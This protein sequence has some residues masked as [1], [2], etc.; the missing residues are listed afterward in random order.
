MDSA[1]CLAALQVVLLLGG[2]VGGNV[3]AERRALTPCQ[4]CARA[5]TPEAAWTP[6][7][8]LRN[9]APLGYPRT[10]STVAPPGCAAPAVAV[11]STSFG[12]TSGPPGLRVAMTADGGCWFVGGDARELLGEDA[13]AMA[14]ELAFEGWSRAQRAAGG[15]PDPSC[16]DPER[17]AEVV[18]FLLDERGMRLLRTGDE[19]FLERLGR[20]GRFT[21]GERTLARAEAGEPT[22]VP[23]A[24]AQ[25]VEFATW[26]EAGGDIRRHRVLAWPDGTLRH[27]EE[28]IAEEIGLWTLFI[29]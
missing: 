21:R 25:L 18:L 12:W 9:I 1:S 24:D 8:G 26:S 17:V 4:E 6:P 11:R 10:C 5:V 2:S 23:M 14:K 22:A 20:G 16:E 15:L 29:R 19:P 13:A 7:E 3:P 27:D 28:L